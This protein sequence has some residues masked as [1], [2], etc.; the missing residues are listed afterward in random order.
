MRHNKQKQRY[1]YKEQTVG[2]H[3]GE[4]GRKEIGEEDEKVHI[5]GV[6]I[7]E[8]QVW[9]DSVRNIVDDYVIFVWWCYLNLLW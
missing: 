2:C 5:Y 1:R 6:K 8:S 9:N 4:E 3:R 7:N